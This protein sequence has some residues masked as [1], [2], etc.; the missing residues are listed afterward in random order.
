MI[1]PVDGTDQDY[2]RGHFGT[3]ALLVEGARKDVATADERRAIVLSARPLWMRLLS[4]F[5]DGPA[6]SGRVLDAA[7][8]PAA[9]AVS[10]DEVKTSEGETWTTRCRD[11]RFDR[12]LPGPGRYTVR[13]KIAG[14]PDLTRSVEVPAG[15]LQLELTLD[16]PGAAEPA[17]CPVL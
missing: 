4:R 2:L 1:Y 10:I 17:R 7:G 15:R 9:A 16:G 13:V 3:L 5:L 11:G 12:Y 8:N 14:Q 6:I